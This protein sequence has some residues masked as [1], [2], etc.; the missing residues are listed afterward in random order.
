MPQPKQK[1]RPY[2]TLD[3]L[4]LISK[5]LKQ[6]GGV[7]LLPL[8]KYFDT[9]TLEIES[10]LRKHN[11]E[12]KPT[13]TLEERLGLATPNPEKHSQQQFPRPNKK[14]LYEAW[15][16]KETLTY[17]ELQRVHQYRYE[18]SLMT[19]EEEQKYESEILGV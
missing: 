16:R 7:H 17:D 1:F 8:I 12:T 4:K 11:H 5:E 15:K 13:P 6:S 19:L 14:F 10:G 2:L 3:E 9:Y 18:N